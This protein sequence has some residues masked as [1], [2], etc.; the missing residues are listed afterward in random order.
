VSWPE[1]DESA[2]VQ[3]TLE[4]IVQVNGKVRG[5]VKVDAS[6]SE[7]EIQQSALNNEN[8]KRFLE[9]ST[10]DKVIVVK[11]RLVNIVVK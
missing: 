3:H 6:A 5:K 1:V 10:I 11:G 7:A 2:L 9:G 4:L 8:V